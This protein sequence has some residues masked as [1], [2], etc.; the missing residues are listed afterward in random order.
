MNYYKKKNKF[1]RNNYIDF[2]KTAN[3]FFLSSSNPID[4]IN[5][6]IIIIIE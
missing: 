2:E 1:F 6:V 5:R 3:T 4:L